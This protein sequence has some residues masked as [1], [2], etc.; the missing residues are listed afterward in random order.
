[1]SRENLTEDPTDNTDEGNSIYFQVLRN[2]R[3]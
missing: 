3:D 2:H 1:M